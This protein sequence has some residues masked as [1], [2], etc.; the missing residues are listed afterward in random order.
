MGFVAIF[1]KINP[2]KN[3]EKDNINK[4]ELAIMIKTGFDEMGRRFDTI[5]NDVGSLKR[6]VGGLKQ[7]V[8]VLKE[9]VAELK[10]GQLEHSSEISSLRSEVGS[11]RTEMHDGFMKTNDK[12]DLL[13]EKLVDKNVITKK[14]AKEVM[15]V[16]PLSLS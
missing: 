10:N 14:D 3:M 16:G 15:A 5:E 4:D 7:D 13:A 12:V 1:A 8:D 11:L 2:Y 9:D 6:D